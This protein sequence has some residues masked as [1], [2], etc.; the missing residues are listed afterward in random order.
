MSSIAAFSVRVAA[1]GQFRLPELELVQGFN[2]PNSAIWQTLAGWEGGPAQFT[3]VLSGQLSVAACSL[4]GGQAC[5][6]LT[7]IV[8]GAVQ[9]MPFARQGTDS[10]GLNPNW[11]SINFPEYVAY[12]VSVNA[13][14]LNDGTVQVF[15]WATYN[16]P[17]TAALGGQVLYSCWQRIVGTPGPAA[18]GFTHLTTFEPQPDSGNWQGDLP[19]SGVSTPFASASLPDGRLQLW[20]LVTNPAIGGGQL[21]YTCCKQSTA[22]HAP[23]SAWATVPATVPATIA[24]DSTLVLSSIAACAG[25]AAGEQFYRVYDT[26]EGTTIVDS[27]QQVYLFGITAPDFSLN[28]TGGLLVMTSFAPDPAAPAPS[29]LAWGPLPQMTGFPQEATAADLTVVALPN[30][31]IQVFVA[32]VPPGG[33]TAT[34]YTQSFLAHDVRTRSPIQTIPDGEFVYWAWSD[35]KRLRT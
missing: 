19:P 29:E 11:Q 18:N 31:G 9:Y 21:I 35:W 13:A 1:L 23:W 25:P 8:D 32:T 24:A 15:V 17:N 34:I 6:F 20:T 4:P 28:Q 22:S 30:A 10:M 16:N 14:Q 33:G 12:P 7:S 3:S 2:D 26:L 5:V 27:V